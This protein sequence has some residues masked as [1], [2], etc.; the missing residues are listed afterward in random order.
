VLFALSTI[1]VVMNAEDVIK[2]FRLVKS[3]T[4]GGYYR[5]IQ[6]V[7]DDQ[8]NV[9]ATDIYYLL[10][11]D[12]ICELHKVKRPTEIYSFHAGDPVELVQV[13]P[14]GHLQRWIL[15]DDFSAGQS[16]RVSV[17]PEVWQGARLI[18]GGKWALLGITGIPGFSTDDYTRGDA[19]VIDQLH[20]HL[21]E[22]LRPFIC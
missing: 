21:S 11:A 9:L 4:E 12:E 8:G 17:P 20:P 7:M 19:A 13:D 16:I 22:T 15:G 1:G 10:K 5:E 18:P 6:R 2:Q 3:P 14:E